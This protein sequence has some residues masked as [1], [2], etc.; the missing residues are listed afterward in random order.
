MRNLSLP[1][2]V[3]FLLLA[4]C[5]NPDKPLEDGKISS[6]S[7]LEA[8]SERMQSS[9]EEAVSKREERVKRGDTI[10]MPYKE[11]QLFLPESVQ[12]YEKSGEPRGNQINMPGMGS[13]S[14]TTQEYENGDKRITIKIL[15]YNAA[16]TALSGITALYSMG[17]KS[18]N[19]EKTE[20]T[21]DLGIPGVTAYETVYKQQPESSLILVVAD[22]FFINLENYGDNNPEVLRSIAKSMD[23]KTLSSK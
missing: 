13:W 12:G 10:A 6:V 2:S 23:I 21:V 4:S 16:E 9:H 5:G 22:R 17:F 19:D 14:E 7:E 8:I 20:G 1:V 15:D 3:C 11:L 18:E